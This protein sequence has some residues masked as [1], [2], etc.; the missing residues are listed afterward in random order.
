MG[1][2]VNHK[3]FELVD[4]F[5][6]GDT[7]FHEVAERFAGVLVDDR[8]NLDRPPIGGHVELEIGRP[9]LVGRISIDLRRGGD[10]VAFSAATL[11]YPQAL[12]APEPLE[13]L[14][15]D[16]PTFGAGIMIGGPKPTTRMV[17][18]P[19]TQP[20]AQ[21]GIPIL[22]RGR[23]RRV[24]LGGAVLPGN[25]AGEPFTDPQHS[26]ELVHGSPPAFRA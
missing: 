14:V 1:A 24:S 13:F 26:L 10:A 11:R 19:G 22:R 21:R 9:H 2:P 12:L 6:G 16:I 17:L 5:L 23:H 7:A 18:G 3:P 25:P 15:I 8:H 4:Q 20:F